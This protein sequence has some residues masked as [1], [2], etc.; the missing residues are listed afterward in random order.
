MVITLSSSDVCKMFELSVV[1]TDCTNEK[2][3]ALAAESKKLQ[4]AVATTLPSHTEMLVKLING[5]KNVGISG[6]VGFPSGGATTA[7]KIFE[8]KE[9]IKAGSTEIDMVM[10]VGMFLSGNYTLVEEDIKRVVET[11]DGIPVKVILECHYLKND[12]IRKACEIC[13]KAKADY[14][15]TGTGWAPAGATLENIRLIKSCVG[16]DAKIKAA[17]GVRG[18]DTLIEMYR[19]GASR[20]G[21][22][23][24]RQDVIIDQINAL[25]EGKIKFTL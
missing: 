4:V 17:G 24:G 2:I 19:R 1:R 18:L 22:G 6:N 8:T 23:L 21:I 25:P 7:T 15:K 9:L 11:A 13:L 5:E 12:Q 20:F 10:N 14:I 16:D 3:N